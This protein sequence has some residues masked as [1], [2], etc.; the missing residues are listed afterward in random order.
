MAVRVAGSARW[1]AVEDAARL[2]DA[3]G[4]ALPVGLPN[5]LLEPVEDPLGDLVGRY[6]RTH[7]PFTAEDVAAR[8][9][10]GPAVV[11]DVLRRLAASGRV[12]EGEFRPGRSG[13]E[14]CDT[15]VLRLIRRRSLAALRAEVEP[16]DPSALVRFLPRWQGVRARGIGAPAA[17]ATGT[18]TGTAS[19]TSGGSPRLLAAVEQLAGAVVPASA[20]ET[21]VLPGRVGGYQPAWL[22]ELTGAGQVL[23]SAHGAL[24]GDDGWLALHLADE[25]PLTLPPALP[26]TTTP[27]QDQLLEALAGGGGRFARDLATAAGVLE[28]ALEPALWELVWAGLVTNDTLGPLRA[29]V[30]GGARRTARPRVTPGRRRLPG[31]TPVTRPTLAGRWSLLPERSPDDTRRAHAAATVLL[32]RHG[33]LTRGSVAAE[34]F[35]GGFAAA[36]RVLSALE[37]AGQC[38]RGYIVEGLGAAQFAVPGAV[39]RLRGDAQDGEAAALVLA[40]ADPANPFGAALPWPE[41]GGTHRPGR[42]AGAVVVLHD[43]TLVLYLERGGRSVL[44]FSD[45]PARLAAGAAALADAARRGA[46]GTLTVERA[47]GDA[48]THSPVATALTGAGFV[49]TP[50]GLRIR[51]PTVR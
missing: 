19:K 9:G 49:L 11:S 12:T 26:L 25:A 21:L 50:R 23:W 6:A 13:T 31:A 7:G 48:V 37:D 10:L 18:G 30:R 15:G 43:G 27:L 47:D 14:W 20:L 1:A 39:D 28:Q 51:V 34:R 4:V 35:P 3:L 2:R 17:A 29:I 33:V 40:A 44:T 36:Y 38:R 22:D 41:V 46:L 16:V 24:P 32:D 8:L 42:K 5:A 45:D